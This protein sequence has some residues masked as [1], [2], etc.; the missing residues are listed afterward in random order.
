MIDTVETDAAIQMIVAVALG[1]L[2]IVW[3]QQ[4]SVGNL[5]REFQEASRELRQEFQEA[6]RELRQEF[7]EANKELR[8]ELQEDNAQMRREFQEANEQV[9]GAVVRNGER[10]ARIEGHLGIGVAAP[11]GPLTGGTQARTDEA[12]QTR[13]AATG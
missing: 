3:N 7:Q 12:T 6:S 10:L 8:R 1:V 9:R 2:T 13:R 11:R 5:R 4:R